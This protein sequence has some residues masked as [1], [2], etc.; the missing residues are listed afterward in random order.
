ME[1]TRLDSPRL[2]KTVSESIAHPH[3]LD[4][5]NAKLVHECLLKVERALK[6]STYFHGIVSTETDIRLFTTLIQI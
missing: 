1:C 4:E 3:H 2:K 5:L 6:D